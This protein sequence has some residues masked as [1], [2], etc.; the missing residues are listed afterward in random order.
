MR[1]AQFRTVKKNG[2]HRD[3]SLKSLS[4]SARRDACHASGTKATVTLTHYLKNKKENE[5]KNKEPVASLAIPE[6]KEPRAMVVVVHHRSDLCDLFIY[7]VFLNH[8]EAM[9]KSITAEQWQQEFRQLLNVTIVTFHYRKKDRSLRK[10]I[11]TTCLDLIP[12]DSLP[13]GI[14]AP[15]PKGQVRYYDFTVSGWR[16]LRLAHVT[17]YCLPEAEVENG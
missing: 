11:G 8:S 17:S 10:A 3:A 5:R 16:T 9:K 7:C 15:A 6:A 4:V 12:T 2:T 13:K 14:G 1:K